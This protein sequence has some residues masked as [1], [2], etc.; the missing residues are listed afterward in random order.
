MG[1]SPGREHG[2]RARERE[3][4]VS[5]KSWV[6][7]VLKR[8][9]FSEILRAGELMERSGVWMWGGRKLQK[10]T[11]AERRREDSCVS[12]AAVLLESC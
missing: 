4:G 12:G 11:Q 2:P 6:D 5:G 9:G 8:R 7:W 10:V 3:E 1:G